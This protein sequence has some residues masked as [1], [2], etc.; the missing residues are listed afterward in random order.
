MSANGFAASSKP[1]L[2]WQPAPEDLPYYRTPRPS[3]EHP[4]YTSF[5]RPWLAPP[6]DPTYGR[7][8]LPWSPR[9]QALRNDPRWEVTEG[10]A[11]LDG[12]VANKGK[13]REWVFH[14][15]RQVVDAAPQA[16][17]T[18]GVNMATR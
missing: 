4:L 7:Y 13:A 12:N 3:T 8:D 2:S 15:V 18:N 6:E 10:R 16:S 1:K 14:Q 11:Y 9:E 5:V 17:Y